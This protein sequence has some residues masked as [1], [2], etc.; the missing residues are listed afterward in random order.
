MHKRLV[1]D[2]LLRVSAAGGYENGQILY[3]KSIDAEMG[4]K[5]RNRREDKLAGDEWMKIIRD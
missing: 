4:V 5:N 3:I 1:L 2:R